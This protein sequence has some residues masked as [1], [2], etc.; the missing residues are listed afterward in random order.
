[1]DSQESLDI[2]QS[3]DRVWFHW[4]Y[5][6]GGWGVCAY[7]YY[8][9]ARDS[10]GAAVAD[11]L[12]LLFV[13]LLVAILGSRVLCFPEVRTC[14]DDLLVQGAFYAWRIPYGRV[15]SV[16]MEGSLIIRTT[17]GDDIGVIAFQGSLIGR[18]TGEKKVDQV[19][20]VILT[21]QSRGAASVSEAPATRSLIPALRQ[22]AY[23][24]G[25]FVLTYVGV[26]SVSSFF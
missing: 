16:E 26:V 5:R 1:M 19:I 14:A 10:Y 12:P 25:A 2:N 15:A 21:Q 13:N 23:V 24:V 17:A 11:T 6:L 3:A 22:T 4:I 20:S 7:F 9:L 18:L 8:A